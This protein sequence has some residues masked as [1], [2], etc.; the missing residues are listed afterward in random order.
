MPQYDI[1]RY[2]VFR[3]AW[4]AFGVYFFGAALFIFGPWINP[5]APISP[6]LANLVATCF[7]A[8]IFVKRFTSLYG[9]TAQE[10]SVSTTFPTRRAISVC[11]ADITRVDLRRGLSQRMLKVAHVW[12]Y[13]KGG[14]EPSLKL[15]GVPE[16][17]KFKQMLLD[18][19]AGDRVVTGAWRR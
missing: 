3:P 16:P 10:V 17:E 19:G 14:E 2:Q 11:I 15:F 8:F 1:K 13:Q 18:L 5:E 12:I 4:Q 6:A 9:V 7:L